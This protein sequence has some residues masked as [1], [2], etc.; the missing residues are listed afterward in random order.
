MAPLWHAKQLAGLLTEARFHTVGL[1]SSARCLVL[2]HSLS[3]IRKGDVL[4]VQRLD[5][6]LTK[7]SVISLVSAAGS[8]ASVPKCLSRPVMSFFQEAA[9]NKPGGKARWQPPHSAAH[10]ALT[11]DGITGL[12]RSSPL[13]LARAAMDALSAATARTVAI[14]NLEVFIGRPYLTDN[15]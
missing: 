4:A 1:I 15:T 12:P 14:K 13:Y 8:E 10:L 9:G 3:L 5:S 6:F 7:K 2:N 11:W